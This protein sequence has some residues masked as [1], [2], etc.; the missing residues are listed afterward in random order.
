MDV[1]G[2]SRYGGVRAVVL[3]PEEL[4]TE[5]ET[6]PVNEVQPVVEQGGVPAARPEPVAR[7]ANGLPR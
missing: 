6:A 5:E 3:L 7:T 1:T 4:W 2:V